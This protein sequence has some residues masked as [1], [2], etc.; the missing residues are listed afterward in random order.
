MRVSSYLTLLCWLA[1]GTACA[2][3]SLEEEPGL[4]EDGSTPSDDEQD[5]EQDDDNDDDAQDDDQLDDDSDDRSDEEASD[6]GGKQ[7]AGRA[8]VDAGMPGSG[9]T[10]A[11]A[12]DDALADAAEPSGSSCPAD[13]LPSETTV[14]NERVSAIRINGSPGPMANVAPGSPVRIEFEISFGSCGMIGAPKQIY[15][16]LEV[17]SPEC[18]L[19]LCSAFMPSEQFDFMVNAPREPG[20]HYVSVSIEE[21]LLCTLN[22]SADT[23][24]AALCVG[25]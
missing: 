16:G 19:A 3:P 23:K 18:R 10:D 12:P 5:D 25:P 21:S 13:L 7:D 4:L 14:G 9:E 24:V 22:G 11:G 15:L 1:L 17:A 6:S 20:L 2:R 8:P